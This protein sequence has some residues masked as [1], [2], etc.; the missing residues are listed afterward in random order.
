PSRPAPPVVSA[1]SEAKNELPSTIY[2]KLKNEYVQLAV[3]KFMVRDT[4][5]DSGAPFIAVENCLIKDI[6]QRLEKELQFGDLIMSVNDETTKTDSEIKAMLEK[7]A[8]AAPAET[9]FEY[10]FMVKGPVAPV[11]ATKADLPQ[12]EVR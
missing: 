5:W 6:D 3:V 1:A 7:V 11:S 12:S 2:D 9:E 10:S 8:A 4:V